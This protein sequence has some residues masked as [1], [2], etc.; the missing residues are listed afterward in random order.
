MEQTTCKFC[1]FPVSTNFYYCPGCGKKLIDPPI[2]TV[3][4]IGVYLVSIFL[5][6]FGLWPGIKYLTQKNEK[7]KRVGTIAI[8]LT[9]ISTVVTIWISVIAINNLNQ[10]INSQ[11]NQYQNLGL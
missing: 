9:I 5:P 7:A 1:G 8:V 6:P 3:R 4:E 2:T 10:T 11:V